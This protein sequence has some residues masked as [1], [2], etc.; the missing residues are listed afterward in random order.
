MKAVED[1][2]YLTLHPSLTLALVEK[3]GGRYV[4]KFGVKKG[5][6]VSSDVYLSG[7]WY[8]PWRYI[9]DVDRAHVDI[10]HK[11]LEKYGDCIGIS[12]SPGDEALIFTTAFLTQNTSY[13]VN[14]LRWTKAIFSTSED[15][16]EIARIA[17]AVGRS[18]QLQRLP[19]ALGKYLEL[20]PRRRAELLE[21]P[22]VGPKVADLYLLFTGDTTA[23]P[24]D[25][26]LMKAAPRLGL[27]GV[28]P[29]KKYCLKYTCDVCP[30]GGSCLR[31]Q[32]ARSFGRLA[33]WLQTV[34]YVESTLR[35]I[36]VK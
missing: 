7:R 9:N 13:H 6:E 27:K 31:A 8:S 1:C 10:L 17:P 26:H 21:I 34:V 12:I 16:L 3:V 5:V 28:P 19:K 4:K 15:P 18:Y 20:K 23:A 25:K 22:G 24:V 30:L 2:L 29:D 36:N 14:V 11:L 33:G 35:Y 32:L